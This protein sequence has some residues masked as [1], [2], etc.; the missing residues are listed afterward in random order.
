[1]S[2]RLRAS[3]SALTGVFAGGR[4][5]TAVLAACAALAAAGPQS[6]AL[7]ED[8]AGSAPTNGAAAQTDGSAPVTSAGETAMPATAP[9]LPAAA[10]SPEAAA[11]GTPPSAEPPPVPP[12]ARARAVP[13]PARA[14]LLPLAQPLWSDL[15]P[16]Q[17]AVLQPFAEQWNSW[18]AQEKLN[19]VSLA[20]RMPRMKVEAR[21]KISQRIREW[22]QLTPEQ[23]RLARQNY[24]LA[25]R[26][27]PDE[28]MAQWERYQQLTPEQQ[29]VLRTSGW[30]SNTA[31]RH[32]GARTGLAKEA[33]QPL[34]ASTY[35]P[36]ANPKRPP[37]KVQ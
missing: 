31:A 13:P 23:R 4:R 9:A 26:L 5:R 30:T 1:M 17:Q 18:P 10:P 28:R 22:A 11:I 21:D 34:S 37:P 33:A 19:W 7:A 3:F 16:A 29:S 6:L 2:K 24:R 35:T 32:A 36:P 25:K 15:T 8:D 14:S 12:S 27:P 20:N